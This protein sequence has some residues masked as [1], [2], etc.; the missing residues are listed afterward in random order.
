MTKQTPAD[1]WKESL[2]NYRKT[3]QEIL[4]ISSGIRYAGVINTYGRTLT[5]IVRSDVKP[6]L[7]SEDVKNEFF[8]I[9][10]LMSLRKKTSSSVGKLDHVILKHQKVTIVIFQKKDISFYVSIERKE[11]DLEKIISSIKK[12]I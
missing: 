3:C 6:M 4:K 8:I 10:T 5:G 12:T 9:S 1:K 11:T 2:S 7:K